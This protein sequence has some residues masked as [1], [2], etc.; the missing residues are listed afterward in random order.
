MSATRF[1]GR[2]RTL[3]VLLCLVVSAGCGKEPGRAAAKSQRIADPAIER[4]FQSTQAMDV[5][6]RG[7]PSEYGAVR[8]RWRFLEERYRGR[9]AH[10]VF[11]RAMAEFEERVAGEADAAA[12]RLILECEGSVTAGRRAEAIRLLRRY[13]GAF[14]GT[15]GARQVSARAAEIER[16]L[17]EILDQGREA[18]LTRAAE[19]SFKD[20]RQESARLRAA[21][22]FETPSGLEFVKEE[23][24]VWL[25]RL[26]K[27][28]DEEER[29]AQTGGTA[30]LSRPSAG[31]SSA[32]GGV[33][34]ASPGPP[35]DL[36]KLFD[37][38]KDSVT[39]AWT[40]S[41]SALVSP[42]VR[43]TCFAS[44]TIPYVPPY[45][46]DLRIVAQRRKGRSSLMVGMVGGGRQFA[47]EVAGHNEQTGDSWG[48]LDRIDGQWSFVNETCFEGGQM[49]D[50]KPHTILCKI[51]RNQV[52][53]A[54]DGRQLV[55]WKA[56]YLRV[57]VCDLCALADRTSLFLG[58]WESVYWISEMV[59][60][61]VSGG[62]RPLR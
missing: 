6:A 53:V 20:A 24:P 25:D 16:E 54:I 41:G 49:S 52:E 1:N 10:D 38:S 3:G 4:L 15:A 28:L 61:P 14:E 23:Y 56:D 9:P 27:V 29:I 39:G 43:K 45:E 42:V 48:G 55:D 62:G 36:L 37:P 58:A 50:G 12:S 22:A 32:S 30:L 17:D 51:R 40:M 21:L 57:G 19:G 34:G 31:S 44:C 5:H 47:V 33:R 2:P 60:T 26:A 35:V 46:Y 8:E 7:T 11:A 13:P 18:A 59:L